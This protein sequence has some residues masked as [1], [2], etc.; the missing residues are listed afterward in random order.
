MSDDA[1]NMESLV[2]KIAAKHGLVVG[3]DDPILV[4]QT[5]NMH[6]LQEATTA[7]QASLAEFQEQI[8]LISQRWTSD[9]QGKAE[10]VLSTALNA[11]RDAMARTMQEG[12][13]A[14]IA[15]LRTELERF[16]TRFE[17]VASQTRSLGMLCLIGGG[18]VL[19]A[20][21]VALWACYV[22]AGR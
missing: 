18:F 3:R 11:S 22:G 2:A 1:G 4:L 16:E 8:E 10:K 12:T 19:I 21:A 5:I 9:A 13:E 6:L 20:S 7:Q 14:A 17:R 15:S